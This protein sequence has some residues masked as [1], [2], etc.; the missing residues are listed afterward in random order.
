MRQ[1]L[2]SL[3]LSKC[4]EMA[5]KTASGVSDSTISS[6]DGTGLPYRNDHPVGRTPMAALKCFEYV[7]RYSIKKSLLSFGSATKCTWQFSG[8]SVS[9]SSSKS[10]HPNWFSTSFFSFWQ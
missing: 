2:S 9:N 10:G 8:C 7:L 4:L 5:S 3:N 1:G 6:S